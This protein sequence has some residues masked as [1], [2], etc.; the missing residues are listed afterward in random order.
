MEPASLLPLDTIRNNN[1]KRG[2]GK[3]V[4][5]NLQ[6]TPKDEYA[7]L[8]VRGDLYTVMVQLMEEL[9]IDMPE[10]AELDGLHRGGGLAVLREGIAGSGMTAEGDVA[11]QAA[12]AEGA[13]AEKKQRREL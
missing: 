13:P 11:K 3:L 4:I 12:D 7:H 10:F 5:I 8:I 9:G 6:A 2:A 1:S